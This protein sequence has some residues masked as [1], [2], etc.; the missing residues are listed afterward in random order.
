MRLLHC[1][2][3]LFALLS[4]LAQAELLDDIWERGSLRIALEDNNPPYSYQEN[5]KL[6]GFDV[7]LAR[8]VAAELNVD[9]D[10]VVED[11][12]R[13]REGLQSGRYDIAL[14]QLAAPQQ[15]QGQEV[16]EFSEPYAF[17]LAETSGENGVA[18]PM[19]IAFQ[20]GNPA[21]RDS[22]NRALI[23]LRG[24]GKLGVMSA[25]WLGKDLSQPP[26][27]ALR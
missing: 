26:A 27:A 18:Q 4:P 3:A 12:A 9:A 23:K 15:E 17:P 14:E 20:K 1:L 25:R 22:L 11:D 10:F 7:E 6:T 21:F 24:D 13:M 16:L 2:P 19:A 8:A 5:G